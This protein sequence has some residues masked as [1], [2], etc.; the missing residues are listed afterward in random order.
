L[1]AQLS[2]QGMARELAKNCVLESFVDG[3]LSLSLAP[4]HKQFLSNKMAQDKLQAA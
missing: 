3:K 2:V 4:Q 1:L